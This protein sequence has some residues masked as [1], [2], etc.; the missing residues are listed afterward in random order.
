[1]LRSMLTCIAEHQPLSNQL[2]NDSIDMPCINLI[3]CCQG[4]DEPDMEEV[5][6]GLT[7][8]GRTSHH[9]YDPCHQASKMRVW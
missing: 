3:Y 1:M 6:R 5:D 2:Q 4:L 9:V 7:D 8:R